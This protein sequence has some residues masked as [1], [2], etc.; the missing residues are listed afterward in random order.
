MKTG[1]GM[2]LGTGT[3]VGAG[4][5]LYGTAMPPSYVPP[6][7]WGEG[8]DLGVYRLPEFLATTGTVMARRG[9]D[10]DER[11]RRYLESCWRKGRG[12]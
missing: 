1:I 2:P 9:V 5:N 12:G 4:A 8:G 7:S 6:F 3:V 10:L 11:G